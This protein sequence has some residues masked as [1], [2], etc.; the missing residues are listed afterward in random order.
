V[1]GPGR[2]STG[3]RI[4][5]RVPA[6]V[7]ALVDAYAKVAGVTRAAALRQLIDRGIQQ[8]MATGA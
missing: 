6:D 5:V 7:L 2:P 1:T 3:T 4:D 8:A